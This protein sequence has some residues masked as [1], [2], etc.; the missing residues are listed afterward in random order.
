MRDKIGHEFRL[1]NV[2]KAA[3]RAMI[4][5]HSLNTPSC[6]VNIHIP[7]SSLRSERASRKQIRMFLSFISVIS[8]SR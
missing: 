6:F 5:V 1:V 8:S 2:A 3:I 7:S 4:E